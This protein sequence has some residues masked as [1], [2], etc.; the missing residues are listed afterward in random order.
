[1]SDLVLEGTELVLISFGRFFM[2]IIFYSVSSAFF[3][4]API[5]LNSL[6]TFFIFKILPKTHPKT[7]EIVLLSLYGLG[8]YR[9]QNLA[10]GRCYK[11]VNPGN[12]H[13]GY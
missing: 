11:L 8:S 6:F 2:L 5:F 10:F 1:M 12:I 3:V 9:L 4:F 7:H 13:S